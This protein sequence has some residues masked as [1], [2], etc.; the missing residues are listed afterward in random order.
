MKL[1]R[2]V[3]KVAGIHAAYHPARVTWDNAKLAAVAQ[4]HPELLEYRKLGKPWVA[5]QFADTAP[6]EGGSSAPP[7]GEPQPP[8]AGPAS[9]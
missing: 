6:G 7:T 9:T 5:L 8:P 1:G 2:S 3:G 4:Q